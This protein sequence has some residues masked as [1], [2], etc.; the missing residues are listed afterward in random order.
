MSTALRPARFRH[1]GWIIGFIF[2]ASVLI[3][4]AIEV[5]RDRFRERVF[6]SIQTGMTLRDVRDLMNRWVE[7]HGTV[8]ENLDR[9]TSNNE[10]T[11]KTY[12]T[13]EYEWSSG[14]RHIVVNFGPDGRLVHKQFWRDD[15]DG[16][17]G[18]IRDWLGHLF[19]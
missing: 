6:D 19:G 4:L 10:G 2:L 18:R 11:L 15:S 17:L 13:T 1:G 14:D 8:H 7:S 5:Q 3:V 16:L 12:G 9:S